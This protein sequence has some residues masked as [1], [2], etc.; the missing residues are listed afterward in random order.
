MV[1]HDD[2]FDIANAY[3]RYFDVVRADTATLLDEV[4]RLRYQ[5]YC[6]ENAFENPAE[7]PDR[8]E[9]DE[10]DHRSV[11]TLLRHRP[12]GTFAGAVRVIL[13]GTEEML[14][15]LP[16]EAVLASEG[17]VLP[18]RLPRRTTAEISRFLVSKEFRRRRGEERY[19]DGG[20][21]SGAAQRAFEERR[22]A[23]YITFG[24]LGGALDLCTQFGVTHICAM[25]EPALIR[26]LRRSGVEFEEI[27][28][29]IE[30]HGLRQ[31]CVARLRDLVERNRTTRT[32]LWQCVSTYRTPTQRSLMAAA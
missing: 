26:I 18:K 8:R 29:P 32:L 12:T 22:T 25:M 28:A 13:P 2:Q 23:P 31:P 4:Y 9:R 14:Q 15:P 21:S 17:R 10:Y 3:T 24:L 19:A 30:H 1:D 6:I 16:V 27:G 7:H 11:H 20:T 5:V